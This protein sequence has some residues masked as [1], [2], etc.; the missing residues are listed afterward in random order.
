MIRDVTDLALAVA[1]AKELAESGDV[2]L[3][4]P[5]CAS[6]D[7]FDNYEQRGQAFVELVNG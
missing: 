4:S 1:A 6:Y 2:I 3:L 5:A 7:Q